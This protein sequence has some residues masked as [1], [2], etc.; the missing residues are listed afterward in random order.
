LKK[1]FNRFLRR[2]LFLWAKVEVFPEDNPRSV[3]DPAR[4][5]LYVLA[6]RGL[7]DLLVLTEITQR[8]DLPD[9]LACIPIEAL[10]QHH[11]VYS[12][13]SRNPLIDWIKRRRKHSVMLTDFMQAFAENKDL[14]LQIVPVSVFWGRPLARHKNWLQVLFADTWSLAGRTRKFFTLLFHGRNT[15]LI[16][17]QALDF[18]S[19]VEDI[20]NDELDLQEYLIT[21]LSQQR[22]ATFG[23]QITSHKHLSAKVIEDSIV[24]E[25]ISEKADSTLQ[26]YSRAHR[27]CREIFADCTQL[28]IEV[29]LRLLRS[30]WN[31]FYSGIEIYNADRIREA[32]LTHQLVYVPCHRSHVDYLLLSYVIYNENLA[33]PYI[34][35]GSN[36]NIPFIGRI[37]RGGG[38]FFIRRSFKDNPLYGAVMRA[39]VNQ[40]VNL[41]V[42]LEYFIEGGRSR[43]G[44]ML[45]PKFGMLGMTVDA[46][47]KN[48]VRPM[49]FVPVYFG[50]E[51]LIEGKSYLGELYGGK[52][53]RESTLGTLSAIFSLKGHFGKVTASFGEPID[54]DELL[55]QHC[56]DWAERA[57]EIEQ[58]PAWYNDS[59]SHLSQE[60]MYGINRACVVNPVNSIATILLATPRQSIEIEE[61]VSQAKLHHQL[62]R[63]TPCLASIRVEGKVNKKQIKR[64]AKQK[65]IHIRKH[66]LGDIVYLKP[67][68]AVLIGYYR[69]N[70]LHS[71][72]IP[73]LIACCFTNV[74]RVS[75]A[76]VQRKIRLLY[77]F[78]KSEIQ[79]E[80][81][82]SNLAG[83]VDEC[84]ASLINE[85]LL[86]QVNQDLRR[87]RRSDHRFMQL[88]R[89]AHIVQPI[90]ERYYMTFIVLWQ[91]SSAPLQEADLEYRCHLL[92][93]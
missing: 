65:I 83:M 77:P 63:R 93:Q 21:S 11:S 30:F 32:A 43:T 66:E 5:I 86:E 78:L 42:P 22:E 56:I 41:G 45:K 53:K 19:I 38:A 68:D 92:A 14:D 50:Y 33:L 79:L 47:I 31:R 13:A 69:N 81:E 74:R 1:Q 60:I 6:D 91:T 16:F 34:A 52:K 57:T 80:W 82:D 84:I 46:F 85:S 54:L 58:R 67:E 3:L 15:R 61:L 76:N 24:Q 18:R 39:Y 23:P 64:I 7:S 44:R 28:T 10:K 48:Q 90:L 20:G 29:M 26:S 70:S 4:P 71:L 75:R 25:L 8:Y 73:A 87:P 27:Y 9:P 2:I 12:I 59:L 88:I 40:L 49:A 37:L 55:R 35:A 17:S 89:L 62:I 72:V 51:K 36:L